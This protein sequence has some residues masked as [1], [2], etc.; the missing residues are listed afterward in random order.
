MPIRSIG[1]ESSKIQNSSGNIINPATLEAV[2]ALA[3][4]N[5]A[6]LAHNQKTAPTGTAESIVGASTPVPWSWA[7]IAAL[8]IG[9]SLYRS[10]T[11]TSKCTQ[12]YVEIN[13]TPAPE[14]PE[15]PVGIIGDGKREMAVLDKKGGVF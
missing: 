11:G 8:Q 9:V 14:G 6:T 3:W 7:D 5:K 4:T 13:Y 15:G 12:V 2:Q 1:S 10:L